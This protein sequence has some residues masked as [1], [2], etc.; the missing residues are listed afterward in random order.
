MQRNILS[1]SEEVTEY[2]AV[3]I[4]DLYY[5]NIKSRSKLAIKQARKTLM[6]TTFSK[7]ADQELR[8]A[9]STTFA[10]DYSR[11]NVTAFQKVLFEQQK[12]V[13]FNNP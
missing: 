7:E 9:L 11:L 12:M 6:L 1:K 10:K 13:S 5:T 3:L 2:N 8:T 4:D